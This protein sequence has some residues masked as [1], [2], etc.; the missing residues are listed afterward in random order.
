MEID[1][2][3]LF[4]SH[5]LCISSYLYSSL[6]L[7]LYLSISLF[8]SL[9][10]FLY[11]TYWL[12]VQIYKLDFFPIWISVDSSIDRIRKGRMWQQQLWQRRCQRLYVDNIDRRNHW[13]ANCNTIEKSPPKMLFNLAFFCSFYLCLVSPS[14]CFFSRILM[15]LLF[16]VFFLQV[17]L[18]LN[19]MLM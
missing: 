12:L 11:S 15:R 7:Y 14:G 5:F 13:L 17:F 6:T 2:S 16:L 1:V 3:S 19:F 8:L 4:L 18:C 10:C 9:C